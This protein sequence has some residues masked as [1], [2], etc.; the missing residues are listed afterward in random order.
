MQQQSAGQC[1]N[2]HPMLAEQNFCPECGEPMACTRGHPMQ[3]GQKFCPEC[4]AP[5]GASQA[6]SAPAGSRNDLNVEYDT[7]SWTSEERSRFTKRLTDAGI[8]WFWRSRSLVVDVKDES[9]VDEMMAAETKTQ[10]QSSQWKRP[11]SLTKSPSDALEIFGRLLRDCDDAAFAPQSRTVW[12]DPRGMTNRTDVAVKQV[13][14]AMVRE[15][16]QNLRIRRK[17]DL[18]A[19]IEMFGSCWIN[20]YVLS[21]LLYGTALSA[22]QY[23]RTDDEAHENG[24]RLI[25]YS[26]SIDFDSTWRAAQEGVAEASAAMLGGS[27]ARIARKYGR[28]W[29]AAGVTCYINGIRI[30]IA[31]Q[32]LFRD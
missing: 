22:L 13:E 28:M 30:G 12:T 31:E 7:S 15:A 9:L 20:G 25:D 21:R 8:A 16:I 27:N 10:P 4:G 2:G 5:S 24:Q 18:N 1:V 14:L 26:E 23:S 32:E 3:I 6:S 29:E 17:S 19:A 11:E